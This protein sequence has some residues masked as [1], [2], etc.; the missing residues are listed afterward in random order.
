VTASGIPRRVDTR[1]RGRELDASPGTAREPRWPTR[2][3]NELS[4]FKLEANKAHIILALRGLASSAG[5]NEF[6]LTPYASR[7]EIE[8]KLLLLL[9]RQ[10]TDRWREYLCFKSR[11]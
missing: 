7:E 1:L 5:M 9:G 6:M 4:I 3:R 2:R 10:I 8:R 11:G